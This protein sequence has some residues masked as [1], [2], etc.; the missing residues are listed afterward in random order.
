M[1]V[2]IDAPAEDV[3]A[4]YRDAE[5]RVLQRIVKFIEQGIDSPDWE[6]QKL[7]KLQQVRT[8]VTL[9][10]GKVDEAA[11]RA[12]EAQ[13]A[14]AYARGGAE[15]LSDLRGTIVGAKVNQQ[16][17]GAISKLVTDLHAGVMSTRAP[18]LG[19]IDGAMRETVARTIGASILDGAR[20]EVAQRALDELL[21]RGLSG[22]TLPSGRQ[23]GMTDYVSMAVRTGV[24]NAQREGHTQTMLANGLNLIIVEP[25]PRACDIC[26][27][28]ANGIMSL[29]GSTGT[30]TVPDY[31]SG[32]EIEVEIDWTIEEAIADGFEHP[33]CRCS[34]RA[35]IPGVTETYERPP[36]DAEGYAAQ[37]RQREIE[38]HIR[39]W[40]TAEVLSISPLRE[41]V[42]EEKVAEWQAAMREHLRENEELKRQGAREQVGR[43]L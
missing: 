29:D 19:F 18:V 31:K 28:Y 21:G 14:A 10:L 32:G 20:R 6:Q 41:A 35:Y 22:I 17:V 7:A 33:N 13:I 34:R 43:V 30:I 40:K 15:A 8:M 24:G 23:M 36:W 27:G 37:Q 11:A 42:A 1:P 3:V 2:V 39:E 12:I 26:D 5:L 25:G 16:Q 9:E 38:R 4:I